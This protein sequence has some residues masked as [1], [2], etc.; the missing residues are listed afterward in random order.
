MGIKILEGLY[1]FKGTK[2]TFISDVD[3]GIIWELDNNTTH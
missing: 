2:I 1:L 3:Q